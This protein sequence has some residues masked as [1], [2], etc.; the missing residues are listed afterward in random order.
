ME[1]E[2]NAH[3]LIV[4]VIDPVGLRRPVPEVTDSRLEVINAPN[5]LGAIGQREGGVDPAVGV[6]EFLGNA[7]DET[8]N[9]N[10][11]HLYGASKCGED[12]EEG[13][14][15]AVV[16]D[17]HQVVGR[18]GRWPEKETSEHGEGGQ[19][20]CHIGR[21]LASRLRITEIYTTYFSAA[22]C[23][24]CISYVT[25]L[26]GNV[27]AIESTLIGHNNAVLKTFCM[28]IVFY[29]AVHGQI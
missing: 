19:V 18:D 26:T 1:Q 2:E 4:S 21:L 10:T 14:R 6:E 17:E 20:V 24:T 28:Y 16:E 3:P 25:W 11:E 13:G 5:A 23:T 8:N 9:G 22:N 7:A 29:L 12:E 27:V 15:S